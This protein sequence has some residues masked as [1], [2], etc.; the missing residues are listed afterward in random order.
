MTFVIGLFATTMPRSDSKSL[1]SKYRNSP[2]Q[3]WKWFTVL[4]EVSF[5]LEIFVTGLFWFVLASGVWENAKGNGIR[6]ATLVMDHTLP[7][8]SLTMEWMISNQP[9]V[10]RHIMIV[11]ILELLYLICNFSYS[12]AGFPPY[13]LTDWRSFVGILMPFVMCVIGILLFICLEWCN[14]KKM[15]RQEQNSTILEI[16]EKKFYDPIENYKYDQFSEHGSLRASS[17]IHP[18]D[19]SEKDLSF[20]KKNSVTSLDMGDG[21]KRNTLNEMDTKLIITEEV[22]YYAMP[23]HSMS[24]K[25]EKVVGFSQENEDNHGF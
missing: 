7:I 18:D 12:I 3:A 20:K 5:T 19:K 15:S 2:I 1:L 25:S 14:R 23:E 10:K 22:N 17:E 4:F 8:I 16:L 9:V 13:Q 6:F 21:N 24:V 11:F